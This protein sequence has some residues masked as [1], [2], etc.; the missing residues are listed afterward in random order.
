MLRAADHT[1]VAAAPPRMK[2]FSAIG[3]SVTGFWVARRPVSLESHFRGN[4]SSPLS[5]R[6]PLSMPIAFYNKYNYVLMSAVLL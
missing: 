6:L 4:R 5:S 3:S 1:E 2:G